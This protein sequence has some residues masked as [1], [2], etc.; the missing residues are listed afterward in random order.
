VSGP[1]QQAEHYPDAGLL[2]TLEGR[3]GPWPEQIGPWCLVQLARPEAVV[4]KLYGEIFST[5]LQI[6]GIGASDV[7][8][9]PVRLIC[10]GDER[11]STKVIK[12]G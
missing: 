11:S 9:L 1:L 4:L 2:W 10:A 3:Q 7:Y 6:S 8:L 5:D 12:N